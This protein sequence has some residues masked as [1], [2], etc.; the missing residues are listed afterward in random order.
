MEQDR[1]EQDKRIIEALRGARKDLHE[2][3]ERLDKKCTMWLFDDKLFKNEDE[4]TDYISNN[5][6]KWYD[7][8]LNDDMQDLIEQQFAEA[9]EIEIFEE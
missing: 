9:E 3:N 4:L 2:L 8:Y 1:I 6:D 7:F 5:L